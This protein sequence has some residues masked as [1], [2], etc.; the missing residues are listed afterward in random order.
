MGLELAFSM[1]ERNIE[2]PIPIVALHPR[3]GAIGVVQPFRAILVSCKGV[4]SSQKEFDAFIVVFVVYE[5]IVIEKVA[6]TIVRRQIHPHSHVEIPHRRW[7]ETILRFYVGIG[8]SM[9]DAIVE[10]IGRDTEIEIVA[11][12]S[13][14]KNVVVFFEI[15][16]VIVSYID[17]L[18]IDIIAFWFYKSLYTATILVYNIAKRRIWT[19]IEAIWHAI[20]IIIVI[21]VCKNR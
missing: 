9:F 3:I 7:R 14:A 13:C 20:E 4:V 10:V 11:I 16:A 5:E 1:Q 19:A 12:N 15:D 21:L 18:K 17:I 6:F 2:T 8:K